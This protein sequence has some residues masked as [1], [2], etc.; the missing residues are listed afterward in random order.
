MT[1]F[2]KFVAATIIAASPCA[3]LSAQETPLASEF[4]LGL[5]L[6]TGNDMK[7]MRDGAGYSAGLAMAIRLTEGAYLRPHLSAIM[8]DGVEGSGLTAKRPNFMGGMDVKKNLAYNISVFGGVFG[9]KWN[10][11]SRADDPMFSGEE[12]NLQSGIKLGGRIGV[13]YQINE[14]FIV[15]AMWSVAEVNRRFS[16]SWVTIGGA[17]RF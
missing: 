14:T 15:H 10:Q 5:M 12:G 4:H 13:D 6:D 16:P 11:S 17:V 9:M 8:F 3:V 2:L 7:A 1:R